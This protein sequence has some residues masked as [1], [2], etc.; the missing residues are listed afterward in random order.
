MM[1]AINLQNNS[2][3]PRKKQKKVHALT[4]ECRSVPEAGNHGRIIVKID[5][6]H[7]SRQRFIPDRSQRSKVTI[8]ES[9]FR[10][11]TQ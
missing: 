8:E 2:S 4:R 6:W 5:L 10:V 9:S 3:I 7:Q 11:R 1:C